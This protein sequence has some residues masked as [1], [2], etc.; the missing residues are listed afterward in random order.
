MII[1][2]KEVD[3]TIFKNKTRLYK[4]LLTDWGNLDKLD[5]KSVIRC[6]MDTKQML[7]YQ[8]TRSFLEEYNPDLLECIYLIIDGV[9]NFGKKF[10]S[11]EAFLDF[12]TLGGKIKYLKPSEK[13]RILVEMLRARNE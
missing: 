12:K 2:I 13:D 3:L 6:V 5:A 7:E 11:H 8:S 4:I 1:E 9:G 10:D